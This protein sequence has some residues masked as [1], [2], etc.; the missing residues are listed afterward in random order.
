MNL[1][2]QNPIVEHESI[3]FIS[4][5][6]DEFFASKYI[7]DFVNNVSKSLASDKFIA[8]KSSAKPEFLASNYLVLEE[9]IASKS[10]AKDRFV[11]LKPYA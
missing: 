11:S 4:L 7:A 10:T 5:S 3:A 6:Y 1:L 8:S 2:P 9:S